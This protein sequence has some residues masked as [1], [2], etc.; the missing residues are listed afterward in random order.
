MIATMRKHGCWVWLA[1][2]AIGGL[3]A[4]FAL[5]IGVPLGLMAGFWTGG[6]E[7]L[8]ERVGHGAGC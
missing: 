6:F 3:A 4:V 2:F 1:A 5:A 8:L 7:R